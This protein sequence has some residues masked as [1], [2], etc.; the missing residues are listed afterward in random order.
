MR[1]GVVLVTGVLC[2]ALAACGSSAPSGAA[3]AAPVPAE[4]S[5]AAPP[6]ADR[7]GNDAGCP[8]AADELSSAT[9]LTWTLRATEADHELETVDG[10]K[11]TVCVFT[12]TD[13]PQAGGDPLVLRTDVVSGPDAAVVRTAYSGSCTGNGGEEVDSAAA[14]GATICRSSGT[15][16]EGAVTGAGRTVEVY[17]VSADKPTAMELTPKFEKILAAVR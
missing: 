8:I 15:V 10:V 13:R 5:A 3:S 14:P 11:A 1:L 6:A 7:P 16:V 17:V 12:S 4:L 9:G 2:L